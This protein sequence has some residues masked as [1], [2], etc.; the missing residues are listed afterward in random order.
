MPEGLEGTR[1]YDP[2]DAE[3]ALAAALARVRDAR[4]RDGGGRRE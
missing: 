3:A 2:G 4:G 1:F